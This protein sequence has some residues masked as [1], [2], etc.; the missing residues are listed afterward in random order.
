LGIPYARPEGAFYV[1]AR[2]AET[3]VPA[4][5]F[6]ERLLADGQVMI[7]SGK[8]YGD[9]TDDFARLSLTQ[10]VPRIREALSRM[11]KVVESIREER[12]AT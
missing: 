6:C 11:A 10:P 9:Y 2:V 1:Y 3:G 4:T 7:F 8:I 12:S 5:E